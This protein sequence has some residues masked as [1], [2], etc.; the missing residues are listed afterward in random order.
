MTESRRIQPADDRE[1]WN[2]ENIVKRF[3][4]NALDRGLLDVVDETRGEFAEQSKRRI[5]AWR[6]AFP[7]FTT[8]IEQLIAEGDWVAFR[9]KHSGTHKGEFLGMAP[10]GRRVEFTS[11]VFNRVNNGVVVENWGLHDNDT[12]RMQLAEKL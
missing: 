1:A 3:V 10:T 8:S 4:Y 5:I 9:L 12:L 6:T 2:K 11:M 7:D